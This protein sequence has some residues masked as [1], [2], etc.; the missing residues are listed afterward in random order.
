MTIRS[1]CGIA[2][3]L[4][5]LSTSSS[6]IAKECGPLKLLASAKLELQGKYRPSIPVTVN[7]SPKRFLLDTGGIYTQLTPRAASELNLTIQSNATP[8]FNASGNLSQG[9]AKVDTFAL[10]GMSS[11]NVYLRISPSN[12]DA[13]GLIAPDLLNRYDV[14]MDFA[15]QKLNYFLSDHCPGKVIYWPHTDAAKVSITLADK[16]WIKVPVTLDGKEFLAIIDTGA[17]STTISTQTALDS[18]GLAPGS[19]GMEPA[20]N[21]NGDSNLASYFHT[22]SALTLDGITIKNLRMVVMPD[23]ITNADA[24]LPKPYRGV[25]KRMEMPE[26]IL[27]MDVLKHLHLYFAFDEHN[28]YVTSADVPSI[29]AASAPKGPKLS[30]AAAAALREARSAFEKKDYPAALVAI[31][32]ANATADLQPFDVL[33][34][35][36][37][38]LSV[39]VSMKDLAAAD[40]DAEAAADSEPDVIPDTDKA[41]VYK[42]A[43][44]LALHAEHYDKAAKY[45]K[46][47][48]AANPPA[49]DQALIRAALSRAGDSAGA[50]ANAAASK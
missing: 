29:E 8:I 12:F 18:F 7:G 24:G 41:R 9:F 34:I 28:L 25:Q 15:G 10:G 27:G 47:Y 16:R 5:S 50:E 20:G 32:K 3:L 44:Q 40:V 2:L 36:R 11:S 30:P 43:L 33:M 38:A 13:D 46:F 39:H 19:P 6:A 37:F 35:H 1:L 21:V 14:E 48:Q 26:L 31:S 45:A 49:S 17:T 23:K 4:A 22:F 42:A